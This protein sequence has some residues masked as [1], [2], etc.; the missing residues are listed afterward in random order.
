VRARR[1]ATFCVVAA[2]ALPGSATAQ[3]QSPPSSRRD[4]AQALAQK[5]AA[6][7][8]PLDHVWLAQADPK[9]R[10]AED[11]A[12][13]LREI[14]DGLQT[15]GLTLV[16]TPESAAR[17]RVACS[18]N[19]RDR[20]CAAEIVKGDSRDVVAAS[21]PRV[22]AAAP[23]APG[24]AALDIRPVLARRDAV[25]DLVE[26]RDRLLV[27]DTAGFDLYERG[28][29]GWKASGRVAFSPPA[30][31]RDARGRLSVNGETVDAFLPGMTCRCTLEPLTAACTPTPTA[32]WP[33][34]VPNSS[35]VAGRNYFAAPNAPPFFSAVSLGPD[36]GSG[37]LLAG[38]DGN[39]HLLGARF[40]ARQ[41]LP[42]LG[43]DIAEV[44]TTCG[45]D[46]QIIGTNDDDRGGQWLR[47]YEVAG[48]RLIPLT[49]GDRMPG[50][51]TAIWQTPA[52]TSVLVVAHNPDLDRYEA[53]YVGLACVR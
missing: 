41:V 47:A 17:V 18:G 48:S 28:D 33:V 50:R 14:A 12:A 46:R 38:I 21:T 35:L 23:R 29:A 52:K 40:D 20:V 36:G 2:C 43:D 6:V 9:S 5:I 27:L 22:A 34:G 3:P 11:D 53:F 24:L 26:V 15:R 30:W 51:I 10:D 37:W 49:S 16:A 42:A 25:L 31:P 19:L 13:A 4:L 44:H 39:L 32:S 45:S 8:A 7:V 1:L